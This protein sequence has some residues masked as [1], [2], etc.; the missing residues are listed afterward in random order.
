MVEESGDLEITVSLQMATYV[1]VDRRNLF[2]AAAR[3]LELF[4]LQ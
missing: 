3:W 2:L 4:I 1:Y